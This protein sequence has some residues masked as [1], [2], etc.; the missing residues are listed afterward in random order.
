MKTNAFNSKKTFVILACVALAFG[1]VSCNSSSKEAGNHEAKTEDVADS[2]MAVAEDHND[3]KFD[4]GKEDDAEFMMKVAETNMLEIELGQLAQKNAMSKE[5][6]NLGSILE[7][8]HSK[9]QEELQALATKKQVSLSGMLSGDGKECQ[10][11]L[12]KITGSEFEKEY[13]DKTVKHHEESIEKF[14]KASKDATDPDLKAW[15]A[16]ML[17]ALR[18]HLDLAITCQKK[19]EKKS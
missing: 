16:S 12:M 17:P 13:C 4:K 15:A 11:K 8:A 14:E 3:A 19:A 7:K 2:T 5:V 1:G 9:A 10:D 18:S 6:K